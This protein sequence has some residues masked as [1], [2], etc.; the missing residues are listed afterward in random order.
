MDTAWL[1]WLIIL[2]C[3]FAKWVDLKISH[4]KKRI[5]TMCGDEL[6]WS[7]CN[8]DKYRI[9]MLYIGTIIILFVNYIK[10]KKKKKELMG[11]VS[12]KMLE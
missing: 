7:F 10:I 11:E 5:V 9:I 2:Y 1:L 6:C 4:Y 12:G 3:L 8:A